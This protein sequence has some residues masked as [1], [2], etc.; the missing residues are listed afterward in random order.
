MA[1]VLQQA[2]FKLLPEGCF[3]RC[4]SCRH[5]TNGRCNGGCLAWHEGIINTADE[6][7]AQK[8]TQRMQEALAAGN[9]ALALERF[10][11]AGHWSRMA[12]PKYMAACANLQLG[13]NAQA[14]RFAA[15]ALDLTT[16][17]DFRKPSVILWHVSQPQVIRATTIHREETTRSISFRTCR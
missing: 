5:F 3:S 10:D 14:F 12:I 8:L 16:N 2:D 7:E 6:T 1:L 17:P 13:N 11:G 15:Q 9:P 4:S